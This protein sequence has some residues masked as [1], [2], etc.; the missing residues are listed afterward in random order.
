MALT[1]NE[2]KFAKIYPF[3][4]SSLSGVNSCSICS[5]TCTWNE[6]TN[7]TRILTK[8]LHRRRFFYGGKFN[9]HSSRQMDRTCCICMH[10]WTCMCCWLLAGTAES[11]IIFI[12][13]C[14][15]AHPT[16]T[17]FLEPVQVSPLNDISIDSAVFEQ[18][19]PGCRAHMVLIIFTEVST[20]IYN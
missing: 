11:T 8:R 10:C 5:M 3:V 6:T 2:I 16:N 18:P 1:D 15:C 20:C 9:Q 13:W 4:S 19:T 12:R 14:Q 17:L 7:R